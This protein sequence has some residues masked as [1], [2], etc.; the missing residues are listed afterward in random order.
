M[1]AGR[2]VL[3]DAR[4]QGAGSRNA[5]VSFAALFKALRLYSCNVL[6]CLVVVSSVGLIGR[7]QNDQ[8]QINSIQGRR[9]AALTEPVSAKFLCTV[10][11]SCADEVLWHTSSLE[12]TGSLGEAHL[13][14]AGDPPATRD[15]CQTCFLG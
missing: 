4:G 15:S 2:K 1:K 7:T 9:V 14:S 13:W 8:L 5:T 3:R 11:L 6:L 12:G 10:R